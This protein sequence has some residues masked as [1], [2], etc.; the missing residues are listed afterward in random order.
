MI[1]ILD[2]YNVSKVELYSMTHNGGEKLSDAAPDS[3]AGSMVGNI[4]KYVLYEDN[5]EDEQ[6]KEKKDTTALVFEFHEAGTPWPVRYNTIS[7]TVITAFKE[8]LE[9]VGGIDEISF[10]FYARVSKNGRRFINVEP[11][12]RISEPAEVMTEVLNE[13]HGISDGGVTEAAPDFVAE[14]LNEAD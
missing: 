3:G 10:S 12:D 14:N 5:T 6:T 1:N 4:T 7:P 2:S 11:L 8:I 9:Q 13:K